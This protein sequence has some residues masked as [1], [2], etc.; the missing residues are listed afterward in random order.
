MRDD[1]AKRVRDR[2]VEIA[3]SFDAAR[4]DGDW[5]AAHG[6]W[7]E[8]LFV[9][10][11]AIGEARGAR[12]EA[13][14]LATELESYRPTRSQRPAAPR[15]EE[16][17]YVHTARF[18]WVC[19]AKVVRKS[20]H[21]DAGFGAGYVQEFW[22]PVRKTVCGKSVTFEVSERFGTGG[23]PRMHELCSDCARLLIFPATAE[24]HMPLFA[25]GD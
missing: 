12:I 13:D 7:L 3:R 20:I 15:M 8:L 14:S 23:W 19:A 11:A 25:G 2:I 24:E 18:P 4:S 1:H 6:A 16:Y 10:D 22:V 9:A 21:V 5:E 17:A